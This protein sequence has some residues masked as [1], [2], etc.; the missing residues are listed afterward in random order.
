MKNPVALAFLVAALVSGAT[1][2]FAMGGMGG[3]G[4]GGP[5]GAHGGG[6]HG[7]GGGGCHGSPGFGGFHGPMG[8]PRPVPFHPIHGFGPFPLRHAVFV[9]RGF[10]FV[11]APFPVYV[12]AVGYV[13]SQPLYLYCQNPMG[14][15]P[16]IQDCPTGWLQVSQ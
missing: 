5:G 13:G 1:T 10:V 6:F 11:G 8:F 9:H 4:G 15:F 7:G 12:N 2:S 14:F 16:D 3:M